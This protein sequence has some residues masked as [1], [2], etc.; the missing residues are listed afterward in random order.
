MILLLAIAVAALAPATA[1]ATN[2]SPI[3]AL[4]KNLFFDKNLSTP[5][6]TAC[7]ACHA[8]QVGWTGP[9]AMINRGGAVYEGAVTGRFGNRKPP[10]SAYGGNS[11]ILHLDATNG[12]TGGMFWDG[13]ATGLTLGDPLAEQAIGP[14][15]NPLEQNNATAGVVVNKVKQSSYANLFKSV[16]GSDAFS[17]VNAAYDNIGR[18]IA[19][20]ERSN[21]VSPYNS[22]Y[23]DYVKSGHGLT[24]EELQGLELFN[25]KAKCVQCHSGKDFTD[26]TYD[27]LGVPK[28]P[29][30]PFYSELA[31]NS[32]GA[33]W[34]D[35]GLGGY[36][37]AAG[38][39]ASVY[40]PAL[41]MFKVPTL[42]NVGKQSG[43]NFPKA[44]GHNGY[45]K[46][47]EEVVHFYN[48]RDT[49]P[50]PAPEYA[51]TVNQTQVGNLGLTPAEEKSI[52]AFLKTLSDVV[53][54][55][56]TVY[57]PHAPSTMYRN[58]HYTIYGY[59]APRHTSGTY[60]VTLKFYLKNS[61]GVYVYHHSVSAKRYSYSTTKTKYSAK[62]SLPHAGRWRV[63]AYHADASH[64][65]SF[66]GYDYITVK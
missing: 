36:L 10:S 55:H 2:L 15:L 22:R 21:E 54:P 25:G 4:G 56:A 53:L 62:V 38:Y 1:F 24:S 60:L 39:D 57:T 12:W 17:D 33:S 49:M 26:F 11:P 44:Y 51:A 6:G 65:P 20:Y 35:Q 41:G 19:A 37:K 42:R 64:A 13:R 31:F 9:D 46:S 30:N 58:H 50:W 34:V 32:L 27:N 43:V 5:A 23:D 61:K 8:S 66:S 18:S 29:M 3:E 63:R 40:E 59:V 28:N 7:A 14:F 16:W 48:T 47:L 52:V 45:F